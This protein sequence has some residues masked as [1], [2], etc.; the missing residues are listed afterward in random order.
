MRKKR[1]VHGLNAEER[2]WILRSRYPSHIHRSPRESFG[3][4]DGFEGKR[5]ELNDEQL[6]RLPADCFSI[7]QIA[8][9]TV[10][11]TGTSFYHIRVFTYL[12]FSEKRL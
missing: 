12:S 11:Q 9:K 6:L 5:H 3:L 1:H 7:V 8:I 2:N 4:D 10:E